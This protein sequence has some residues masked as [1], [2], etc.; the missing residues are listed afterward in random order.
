MKKAI[1]FLSLWIAVCLLLTGCRSS[2]AVGPSVQY[3]LQ[4]EGR[5]FTAD[6]TAP[7][8]KETE[9]T[10]GTTVPAE[11]EEDMNGNQMFAN[12]Q[13][14]RIPYTGNRSS[15]VY[16]TDPAQLPKDEAFAAYDG[17][18]FAAHALVLVTDTVGSG[19][20]RVGI[21]D[22]VIRGNV[23]SVYVSRELPGDAG[24]CDMA[25]WYIWAEVEAGLDCRW[26]V[27]NPVYRGSRNDRVDK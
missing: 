26:T 24:T 22:I 14:K 16:V 7:G 19:S 20:I 18:F 12:V 23:A 3:P 1:Q 25:T 4:T 2:G 9:I 13:T 10:A 21:E 8:K 15:V 6:T 17:E 11:A 27:A 5:E